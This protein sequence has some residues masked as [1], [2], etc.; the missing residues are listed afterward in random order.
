MIFFR[1]TDRRRECV[2]V[3]GDDDILQN[4]GIIVAD[5]LLEISVPTDLVELLFAA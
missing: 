3:S 2:V 4:S 1:R 5:L